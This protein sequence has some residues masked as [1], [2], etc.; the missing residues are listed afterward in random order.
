M[1]VTIQKQ[2]YDKLLSYAISKHP[3]EAC[4]LVLG[5]VTCDEKQITEILFI[6]N[7]DHSSEH[8]TISPSAQLSAVKYARANKLEILGNWHSH[9]FTPSR[10]SD[11]DL[12]LA[13]D[14]NASYLILSLA[15]MNNPILNS[16]SVTTGKSE[17]ENLMII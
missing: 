10:M 9:P 2:E 8:F 7:T 3:E 15:D 17:R 14:K 13:L 1:T 5:S 16:F 6:E 11:E 4:G 12:R